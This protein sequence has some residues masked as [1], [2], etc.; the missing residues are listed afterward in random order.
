MELHLYLC[1]RSCAKAYVCVYVDLMCIIVSTLSFLVKE[2]KESVTKKAVEFDQ[3]KVVAATL[4]VEVKGEGWDTE[5]VTAKNA[6][7]Q[8]SRDSL[9]DFIDKTQADL[10][11]VAKRLKVS[12]LQVVRCC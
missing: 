1:A 12:L 9:L 10:Q 5:E 8:Q 6:E 7:V 2:L 4:E 11:A 3:F